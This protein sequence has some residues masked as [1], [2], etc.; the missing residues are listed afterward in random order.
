M[1]GHKE[2]A[3]VGDHREHERNHHSDRR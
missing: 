2:S 3:E 1:A